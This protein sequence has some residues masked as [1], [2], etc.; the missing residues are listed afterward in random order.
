LLF[1]GVP[2]RREMFQADNLHP[3]AEAQPILMENVW[4]RLGAM[5]IAA[6]R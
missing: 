6:P 1:E 3:S 4:R 2:D 5:V